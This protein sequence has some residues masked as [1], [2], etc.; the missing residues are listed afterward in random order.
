VVAIAPDQVELLTLASPVRMIR[1][2]APALK[3]D[4]MSNAPIGWWMVE[5]VA[6]PA[7]ETAVGRLLKLLSGLRAESLV[8]ES[9]KPDDLTRYGLDKPALKLTWSTF[10]QFSMTQ[11]LMGPVVKPNPETPTLE[12][13]SLLIGAPV[14]GKPSQRYAIVE[15]RSLVFTLGP[16][17][18]AAIDAEFHERRVLTFDPAHVRRVHL[19][20]PDRAFSLTQEERKGRRGWSTEGAVDAPAFDA[21]RVGPLLM[22]ASELST[23]RFIQYLGDFPASVGLTPPSLALRVELD[24]GTPPREVRIGRS[25]GNGLLYATTSAEAK[26]PIFLVPEALFAD[27]TTPPRHHDDLPDNVF[28]P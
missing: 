23:P 17:V 3:L 10:P 2:K 4:P 8:V 13:H 26:G 6:A 9:S 14:P 20:W 16:D 5:P 1:L 19:A 7:D 25:T 28:A 12:N 15:G 24:D 11:G 18:L 27:W 22:T 21:G